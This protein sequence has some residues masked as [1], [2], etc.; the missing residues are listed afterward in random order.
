MPGTKLYKMWKN[1]EYNPYP[2]DKIIEL[3]IEIKK[4]VPK[5]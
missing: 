2:Q 1:K 5:W 4:L 3:I